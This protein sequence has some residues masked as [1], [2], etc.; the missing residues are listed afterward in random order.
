MSYRLEIT[1]LTG[2]SSGD[3]FRFALQAGE[4]ISIGR[5]E[6]NDIVLSDQRV[7]RNHA[8]LVASEDG[9][10][11]QDLGSSSGTVHMGFQ[12]NSGP[13][14]L[15]LLSNGDE[16]KIAEMLF[17]V[18]VEGS[19]VSEAREEVE[20][21]AAAKPGMRFPLPSKPTH[22]LLLG[23]LGILLI[24]LLWPS[25][26][27]KNLPKQFSN[28]VLELPEYSVL[29]YMPGKKKTPKKKKDVGHIDKVQFNLPSSH[30]IIEYDYK[31][32][33]EIDILVDGTRVETLPAFTGGWSHQ[34][35]IARDVLEGKKRLL[36]FDNVSF[37]KKKGTKQKS[38]LK[39]WAVRNVRATPITRGP[40]FDEQLKSTI[41]RAE[42]YDRTPDGL[43][44]LVRSLQQLILELLIE[45]KQDSLPVDLVGKDEISEDSLSTVVIR[46]TLQ[47]IGKERR[48][49][50]L[51]M[52]TTTLHL[53][54]L[55][56]L[57][58]VL[59]AELWRRV[60][61]N[62]RRATYS[63]KAKNSI[64]VLD[65]LIAVKIM[66]PDESDY[67]WVRAERMI[68]NNRYVPKNVRRRPDKYR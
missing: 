49:E 54:V 13:N 32:E 4:S 67:R 61:G 19:P 2:V 59:E 6:T 33:A 50:N 26:P 66:I 55:A 53:N 45:L 28:V 52:E 44:L 10:F 40:D 34:Q 58:G 14:D 3:V 16:F 22:K 11:I 37:P 63:A 38:G 5:V 12:L 36:V 31:S 27:K 43:F 41:T 24:L 29:G 47:A 62:F 51:T 35:L 30:V 25:A 23:L 8:K 64:V 18:A 42:S 1:A 21:D 46:E 48:E 15:R 17:K 7:S 56:K 65:N 39:R 57:L 68:N 20:Q 9:V 60:E